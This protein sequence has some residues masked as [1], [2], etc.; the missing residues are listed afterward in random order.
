MS[1][2]NC[3]FTTVQINQG[4][5]PGLTD[6]ILI[7]CQPS[8]QPLLNNRSGGFLLGVDLSVRV[9]LSYDLNMK[10]CACEF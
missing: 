7:V 8:S 2:H 5:T 9:K 3:V 1:T 10:L 6:L 4:K